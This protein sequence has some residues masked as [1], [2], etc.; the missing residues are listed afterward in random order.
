MFNFGLNIHADEEWTEVPR[1]MKES[2]AFSDDVSVKF[3]PPS[4]SNVLLVARL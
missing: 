4:L 2:A 3:H 1:G